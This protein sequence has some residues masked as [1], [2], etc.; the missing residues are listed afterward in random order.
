MAFKCGS[1]VIYGTEENQFLVCRSRRLGVLQDRA[2]PL[3]IRSSCTLVST[4]TG[5][6]CTH[7]NVNCHVSLGCII[8]L[9]NDGKLMAPG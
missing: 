5:V 6:W 7:K 1:Q 4:G 9:S 3:F 2:D 8:D